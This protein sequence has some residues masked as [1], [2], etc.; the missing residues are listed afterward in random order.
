MAWKEMSVNEIAES[1]GVNVGEVREKQ[2]LV[3]MIVR[4]RKAQKLSQTT[5]AKK[6]GVTQGR[7]AQIESG[8]G[9]VNVTFDLLLSILSD[10]GYQFKI[11][12]KRAA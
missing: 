11:V 3:Q 5:L 4:A 12:T 9:T 2:H 7:I 1:L 8:I 10:L 6:I